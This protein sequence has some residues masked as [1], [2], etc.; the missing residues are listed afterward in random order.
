MDWRVYECF[1]D[2][3]MNMP[4]D[5]VDGL[6]DL[7]SLATHSR[8]E[9][10]TRQYLRPSFADPSGAHRV[11]GSPWQALKSTWL[12]TGRTRLPW[13]H[14]MQGENVWNGVSF[15]ADKFVS[16]KISL[17]LKVLVSRTRCLDYV[18]D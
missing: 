8:C 14:L 9:D 7:E 3:M 13:A 5:V 4:Y 6:D 16:R 17:S 1:Y 10:T 15:V 11:S 18:A 2:E 12:H